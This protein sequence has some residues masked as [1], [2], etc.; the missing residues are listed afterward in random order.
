MSRIGC[1]VRGT[2]FMSELVNL[3]ES[4]YVKTSFTSQSWL[5]TFRTPGEYTERQ[6]A[7]QAR[8]VSQMKGSRN[9]KACATFGMRQQEV[10][11]TA[12]KAGRFSSYVKSQT[13]SLNFK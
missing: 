7:N 13:D 9:K 11:N 6:T 1:T 8:N 4:R 3:P 5:R 10:C 2:E 12:L